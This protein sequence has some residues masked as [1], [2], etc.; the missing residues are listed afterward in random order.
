MLIQNG[1]II[2]PHYYSPTDPYGD[3]VNLENNA[4]VTPHQESV[5]K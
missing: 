3:R 4:H 2:L 1:A 5:E